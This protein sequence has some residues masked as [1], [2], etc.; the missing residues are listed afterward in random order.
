M[1]AFWTEG[2][3]VDCRIFGHDAPE[4]AA[5][6]PFLECFRKFVQKYTLNVF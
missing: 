1:A 4:T 5:K 6:A 3:G 2:E